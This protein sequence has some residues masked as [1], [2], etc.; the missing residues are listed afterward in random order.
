MLHLKLV[1]FVR[2]MIT[3]FMTSPLKPKILNR[4]KSLLYNFD[5]RNVW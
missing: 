4:R 2:R 5:G 1:K 3:V